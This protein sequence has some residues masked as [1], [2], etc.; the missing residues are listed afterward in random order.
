MTVYD[1]IVLG[2]GGV[3]SA[4]LY[5]LAARGANVLGLDRFAPPHDKGSSHG[6]ALAE[7][8]LHGATELPIGFLALRR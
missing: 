5:Q 6:Q 1:A 8:A 7:L 3:G 2:I 4:A